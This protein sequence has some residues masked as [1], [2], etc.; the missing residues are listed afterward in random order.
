MTRY[1]AYRCQERNCGLTNEGTCLVSIDE[2]PIPSEY[3]GGHCWITG[4]PVIWILED[5][6]D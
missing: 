2:M 4:E 3:E 6:Q 1:W 5:I